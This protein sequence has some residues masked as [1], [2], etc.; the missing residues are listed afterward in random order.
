M[1]GNSYIRESDPS[2]GVPRS[3]SQLKD[4]VVSGSSS[5]LGF[6]QVLEASSATL[7]SFSLSGIRRDWRYN[8]YTMI[9]ELLSA[10]GGN[11]RRLHITDHFCAGSTPPYIERLIPSLPL[12]TTITLGTTGYTAEIFPLLSKLAS[13][14]S[15]HVSISLHLTT[16]SDTTWPFLDF[17]RDRPSTLQLVELEDPIGQPRISSRARDF[18]AATLQLQREWFRVRTVA[19]GGGKAVSLVVPDS[20]AR[21]WEFEQEEKVLRWDAPSGLDR[22]L[23]DRREIIGDA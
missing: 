20:W 19:M 7:E 5:I 15:L 21:N 12:L 4:M 9:L 22:M 3:S 11:L 6:T 1:Y 8:Q 2:P 14:R 17:L 10:C 23:R 13:L 18:E 16:K